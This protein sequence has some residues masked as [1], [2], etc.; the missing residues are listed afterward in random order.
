M[1]EKTNFKK[2]RIFVASPGDAKPERD[3]VHAIASELNRTVADQLEITLHVLDWREVFPSMGRPEQVIL[4]KLPVEQWDIFVGVLWLRFG[5]K[6]GAND[7]NTGKDYDSGTEEEFAIAYNSWRKNGRPRILFYRCIRPVDPDTV[8]IAQYNRVKEFFKNFEA[9]KDRPGLYQTFRDTEEFEALL[10]DALIRMLYVYSEEVLRK[11][12]NL[13]SDAAFS[14]KIE[15]TATQTKK[16]KARRPFQEPTIKGWNYPLSPATVEVIGRAEACRIEFGRSHLDTDL[17]LFGLLA[18]I[19]S[20]LSAVLQSAGLQSEQAVAGLVKRF[21]WSKVPALDLTPATS[22]KTRDKAPEWNFIITHAEDVARKAKSKDVRPRDLL[23]AI[24]DTPN[25]EAYKW[26]NEILGDALP[27]DWVVQ[28]MRE[29]PAEQEFS[30]SVLQRR[31]NAER[32]AEARA[33]RSDSASEVDKLNFDVHA[34]AL[35]EI[36]LKPETAPPVVIGV[37]G[38]WGS[39]KSTFLNLVE[40]NLKQLHA[41]QKS[42]NKS[43]PDLLTIEYNAWAYTDAAKLWAGLVQKVSQYLNDKMTWWQRFKYRVKRPLR[44]LLAAFII[45]LIPV[46]VALLAILGVSI[47]GQIE[48][49]LLEIFIKILGI[50]GTLGVSL[51]K[52][53]SFVQTVSDLTKKFDAAEMTGVMN[54]VREEMQKVVKDYFI[55][56]NDQ[57]DVHGQVRQGKIKVVI[58]IDEL[59]RCP[60]NR[61]VDILEAIKLFLA[62]EIFI[63]LM[64]IDTRVASEAIQLYYKDVIN[65]ELA[66]EYLEKIV[67]IP[68]QVPRAAEKD[69]KEYLGDLMNIP[70]AEIKPPA[71]AQPTKE[72]DGPSQPAP[73]TVQ[74]PTGGPVLT[75]PTQASGRPEKVSA[76]P[77]PAWKPLEL[78]DTQDEYDTIATMGVKFLESNPRRMKRLLNTYRYVKIICKRIGQPTHEKEWQERMI[79]WL[80]FTLVWPDF[81][82]EAIQQAETQISKPTPDFVIQCFRRFGTMSQI[83]NAPSLIENDIKTHL[84]LSAKQVVEMAEL[85]SNFLIENPRRKTNHT[86]QEFGVHGS[87]NS[88]ANTKTKRSSRRA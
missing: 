81:M 5:L 61:I 68:L 82:L 87:N 1:S 60:L 46:G 7:P 44:R 55:K 54:Q 58:F 53:P 45:G 11:S 15:E 84:N 74:T 50:L 47:F 49:I 78:T 40:S 67:Q 39:G 26:L 18:D 59:D 3:R 2:L 51:Y 32:P 16:V 76:P 62:E 56:E 13:P 17:L 31:I 65:P 19:D 79:A 66:R 41:Q 34:K 21:N 75:Q 42:Q 63:V 86:K 14:S 71:E 28:T 25:T 24:L 52:L 57:V 85:A 33:A 38:P 36:I 64:A 9:D 35:A 48:N 6:P 77:V 37:Y 43:D 73:V 70:A 8:D 72:E 29:W 30:V 10:R 80:T 23:M 4:D 22:I 20:P 83:P 12:P 27:I 88:V 69:V